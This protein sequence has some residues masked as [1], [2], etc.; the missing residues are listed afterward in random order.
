MSNKKFITTT[1]P[2]LSGK[3]HI[4]HALEFLL[5]DLISTYF[6]YKIG[7]ENVFFNIGVDEHGQKIYQKSI[8]EEFNS[9]QEYC[10]RY[11]DIWKDFCLQFN[12]QY[13]NFYRTTSKEHKDGVLKFYSLIRNDLYKKNYSGEYCLGCESFITKKEILYP[14]SCPSHRTP[15]IHLEEENVFFNLNK[16]S[17]QIKDTLVDKSLSNELK[18]II[19]EDYD[20]SITRK[21]VEWGVKNENGETFYV[22]AE[23]LCSYILSLKY[24][25]NKLK[26]NDW[27]ENSLQIC[28]A[29]NLKFQ[30][31]I[32]PALCLAAGIPQTKEFLIHGI[33]KDEKGQKMS[34][35]VGNIVDPIIQKNKFGLLSV[36]YYLL[37]VLNI[38]NNS[39]Y[40]EEELIN[41]WNSDIVNGL[42][43]T[44]AR[45]IHLVDIKN[46]NL[47]YELLDNTF[48]T[49]LETDRA[50]IDGYF[51]S[52]QFQE[53]RLAL[54]NVIFEINQRVANEKPFDKDCVDYE[55]ILRELYFKLK[56][57]VP[58]YEII[59]KEKKQEL[60]TCFIE[61]KKVILFERLKK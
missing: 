11:V 38:F 25:D 55:R 44:V 45:I 48:K 5:G 20:L 6:K 29:D 31:Y 1:L 7:K 28:G 4:G 57:I 13:D 34:K 14:N 33:I 53:A 35:S 10:D 23:A 39:K 32:F 30:S 9:P 2:Y 24:F 18:N 50:L 59:F 36:R 19:N 43:N 26:F 16:Y 37:F 56:N 47:D 60:E 54:N 49:Q 12:I 51:E 52:Y 58:F 40:K 61:N 27:W 15:L 22:W 8:D 42:G 21:N 46:V 41:A 3:A 17:L